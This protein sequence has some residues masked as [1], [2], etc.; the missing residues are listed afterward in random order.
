VGCSF[1]WDEVIV[2]ADL[3]PCIGLEIEE[4]GFIG[5]DEFACC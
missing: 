4:E 1:A 2:K 3:L 5:D